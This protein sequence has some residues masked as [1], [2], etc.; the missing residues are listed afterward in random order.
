MT[1]RL[2]DTMKFFSAIVLT[3]TALVFPLKSHAHLDGTVHGFHGASALGVLL[4]IWLG[5][6]I[7]WT[8]AKRKT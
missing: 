5:G 1:Q 2:L 6:V 7:V 4:L 3:T 8:T